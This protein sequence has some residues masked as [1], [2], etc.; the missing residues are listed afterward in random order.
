MQ[1]LEVW[2]SKRS[3]YEKQKRKVE[4]VNYTFEVGYFHFNEGIM[5]TNIQLCS[6]NAHVN[7]EYRKLCL[8]F[9]I[10]YLIR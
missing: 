5:C 10:E 1:N 2:V 7:D 6:R 4:R 8:K 3:N 9:H